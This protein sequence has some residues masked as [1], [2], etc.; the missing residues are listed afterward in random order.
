[1]CY[2]DQDRPF[3]ECCARF[4][5]YGEIPQTAVELMR[6]RYTAFVLKRAKYIQKT[7][8]SPALDDFCE[9][10]IQSPDIEW[11][12]LKVIKQD[13]GSESDHVGFVHFEAIYRQISI[14][15]FGKMIENSEFQKQNNQWF[16][17][18]SV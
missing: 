5:D 3:E 4:L 6:S 1:M 11:C 10:S 2:C 17:Y 15:E 14:G 9:D 8:I 13:F 18:R 7:M 12:G 16:Y